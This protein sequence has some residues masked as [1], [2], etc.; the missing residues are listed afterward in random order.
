[1]YPNPYVFKG[2]ISEDTANDI[3]GGKG[4]NK[5]R[6]FNSKDKIGNTNRHQSGVETIGNRL[7]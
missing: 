2:E 4:E 5:H 7:E 1:M 6:G 3:R